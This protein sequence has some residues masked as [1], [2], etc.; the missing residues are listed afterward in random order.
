MNFA[1]GPLLPTS[2]IEFPRSDAYVE[3]RNVRWPKK[4]GWEIEHGS[5]R[6][7]H[8]GTW[9]R[10]GIREAMDCYVSAISYVNA[11]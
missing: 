6:F 3:F 1:Q 9:G 7:G 4:I 8:R 5:L 2:R 11:H 10:E